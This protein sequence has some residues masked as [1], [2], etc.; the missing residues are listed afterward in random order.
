[1]AGIGL[2]DVVGEEYVRN[3]V[4]FH[5]GDDVFGEVDYNN[6]TFT[7]MPSGSTFKINAS[8]FAGYKF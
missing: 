3:L 8:E 6:F 2:E 5:I 7:Y 4:I 1:M